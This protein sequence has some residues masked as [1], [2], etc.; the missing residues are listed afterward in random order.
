MTTGSGNYGDSGS[1]IDPMA[2]MTGG[3]GFWGQERA[4][5][6]MAHQA[7]RMIDFQ[8]DMSNTAYQRSMKDM[9]KAGLN[10]ILAAGAAPASTP[11]GAMAQVGNSIGEGINTGLQAQRTSADTALSKQ[12]KLLA[13]A[14][15]AIAKK[16]VPLAKMQEIATGYAL[17]L[18]ESIDK[19]LK[20]D[21]PDELMEATVKTLKSVAEAGLKSNPAFQNTVIKA[22]RNKYKGEKSTL[23]SKIF[24]QLFAKKGK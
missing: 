22:I 10:P 19:L 11:M 5:D 1:G 21:A 18:V 14:Q 9:K 2:V 8:R 23:Y 15:T 16:D 4:N 24:M 6:A 13:E 20:D 17:K 3:L 12:K 7:S